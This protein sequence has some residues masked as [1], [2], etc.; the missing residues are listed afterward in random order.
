[1]PCRHAGAENGGE[2]T[3]PGRDRQ[4]VAGCERMDSTC[5]I[6]C[7]SRENDVQ[8]T[9]NVYF[10]HTESDRVIGNRDVPMDGVD[11][12]YIVEDIVRHLPSGVIYMDVKGKILLFNP[13]MEEI[14]GVPARDIV[15]RPVDEF[16]E[17]IRL[18][19]FDYRDV[20]DK[21]VVKKRINSSGIRSDGKHIYLGFTIAPVRG[22][23]N[24]VAGIIA[25]FADLTHVREMEETHRRM[26]HL[27]MIGEMSARLAHEIKNP[28]ASIIIGIQ[29]FKQQH[30]EIKNTRYLDMI[31]SE[32]RRIDDLIRDLL[33]Y[34]RQTVPRMTLVDV[35]AMVGNV[36]AVIDPRLQK[37]GI[38][39]Q[40]EI[41]GNDGLYITAD[42]TA[43]HQALINIVN[44]AVDAMPQG[45]ALTITVGSVRRAGEKKTRGKG[46]TPRQ[47]LVHIQVRDTG[48]GIPEASL[49]RIFT[50]FYSTKTH[51][52]GL[53]LSIVKNIV[54]ENIGKV[55][56]ISTPGS[57][58]EFSLL[59][60]KGTRK[61]C[62]EIKH[63]PDGV[64]Q[65]CEVYER[66][67]TYR[68]FRYKHPSSGCCSTACTEC[69]MYR[70]GVITA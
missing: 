35:P 39:I 2:N 67:D 66:D 11:N 40:K 32:I 60:L 31:I 61:K 25:L 44:N 18:S 26:T 20:A 30:E 50:P 13:G 55:R 34:S 53:G 37:N 8:N 4:T 22:T 43:M 6:S 7:K 68:C 15:N 52:T 5:I 70:R 17:K 63:C 41:A 45:G 51:G 29:L 49:D 33:A 58:T 64:R 59:F 38:T 14:S 21:A 47:D 24:R 28:L 9:R 54:E 62:Y 69:E 27:A 46:R 16:I 42:E 19:G 48:R 1:M 3:L 12:R 23:D 56:V 65:E 57:G 10:L 36:L